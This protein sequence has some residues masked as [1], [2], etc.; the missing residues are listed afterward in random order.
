MKRNSSTERFISEQHRRDQAIPPLTAVVVILS[1][2]LLVIWM[3]HP[4]FAPVEKWRWLRASWIAGI[5]L[6]FVTS[7]TIAKLRR[8]TLL[9]SAAKLDEKLD[10]SARLETATAL[11]HEENPLARAQ[12]N[13]TEKF[14][15]QT[16]LPSRRR[17]LPTLGA[18]VVLLTLAHAVTLIC[19]TRSIKS[20]DGKVAASATEKKETPA[21]ASIEWNSPEVETTAVAIEEVPLESIADSTRG[22]TNVVLEIAVNG[23]PKLTQLLPALELKQAG[24]HPLKTSIYLDR[25][26]VKTYDMISY[27][28]RAQRVDGSQLPPTVSPV[29]FVQIKPMRED[30]FVCAGG[31]KPSQCF[32]YVSA[33]KAA[34]LRLMK[35]NFALAHA[36]I[37]RSNRDWSEANVRVGD[38][39]KLLAEKAAEV[40]ALMATNNY[41]AQIFTL[42]EQL[43]PLMT[44]AADKIQKQENQPA[45]PPQGK[46]LGLLTEVEK[47]LLNS[48][49]LAGTS[50]QPPA[51]DPFKKAK[52]LELK[53]HP[54]TKAGKIDALAKE[55][56]RLAG[57][58]ARTDSASA[59]KLPAPDAK[60]ENAIGGTPAEQQTEIKRRINEFL[61]DEAMEPDALKHLQ[62]SY[63]SAGVSEQRLAE[64]DIP[65]AREPA[66]E[67]AR[68]LQ[69][70]ASAL[71]AAGKQSAKN[72]LADA[73]RELAAAAET[74]RRASTLGSDAEAREQTEK[75]QKAV[76]EAARRLAEAA[77]EQQEQGATN[78][79][80]RLSEMAGL[81]ESE[82]LKQMLNDS[83]AK[84]RD[85]KTAEALASRLDQLAERAAKERNTSGLSRSELTQLTEKLDRARVNMQR[86]ASS[87]SNPNS[88]SLGDPKGGAVNPDA[89]FASKD[90]WLPSRLGKKQQRLASELMDDLREG[91]LDALSVVPSSNELADLRKAL[92]GGSVNDDKKLVEL[93]STIDLPLEGLIRLL[94][95]E[96]T[97]TRRIHQLT[98]QEIEQAPLAYRPAVAEYFEK[99]SKDYQPAKSG[100]GAAEK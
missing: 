80:A 8:R 88:S 51:N 13:E 78:A 14:L 40:I 29:Q 97:Q 23:E 50:T 68:E 67:T 15:Q 99:L 69:Q 25:L 66:A 7:L 20:I 16:P 90:G 37:S 21:R 98:T 35:E 75:T 71:R 18:L 31:D 34:Q 5:S 44:Q 4:S 46:A 61:K 10:A 58:L 96:I 55:Q 60:D 89:N 70:T 94:R 56:S 81:L 77:R 73:L 22:L 52:N 30:T 82:S 100:N 64:G 9:N 49:K 93:V 12:R 42:V 36:E 91:A 87:C 39:Q 85:A 43:Q 72:K 32:N 63:S 95:S 79:A 38:E 1:V 74:A 24:R 6:A 54:L 3:L 2:T 57:D 11:Q 83:R 41:P 28:L 65:G 26:E 86:L 48:I 27:H 76:E 92:R 19:W 45:L 47:Y 17:M 59:I 33:L 53:K 84:P 62:E